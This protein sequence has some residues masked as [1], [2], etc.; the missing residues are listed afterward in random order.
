MVYRVELLSGVQWSESAMC[1]YGPPPSL[2]SLP[3]LLLTHLGHHS[4]GLSSVLFTILQCSF[5]PA[6]CFI[7]GNLHMPV[8]ISQLIQPSLSSAVST[9]SFSTS[10]SLFLQFLSF[11]T[12][13]TETRA[14]GA[15]PQFFL[16]SEERKECCTHRRWGFIS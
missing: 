5:L 6:V 13:S 14:G 7:P 1:V 16:D 12:K 4:T 8:L 9:S 11:C 10:A 2:A 3:P 15:K